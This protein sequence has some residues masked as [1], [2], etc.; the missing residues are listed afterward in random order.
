MLIQ[1]ILVKYTK[2]DLIV[3][4]SFKNFGDVFILTACECRKKGV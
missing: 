3:A 1:R 4:V 2:N